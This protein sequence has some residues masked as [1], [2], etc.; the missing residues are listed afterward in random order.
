MSFDRGERPRYDHRRSGSRTFD[1]RG[2][3]SSSASDPV[4]TSLVIVRRGFRLVDELILLGWTII[5]TVIAHPFNYAQVLMQ[6]KNNSE[7]NGGYS[8]H[9]QSFSVHSNRFLWQLLYT[10]YVQKLRNETGEK[11]QIRVSKTIPSIVE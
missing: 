10:V 1:R 7:R 5:P 11:W 6:V 4:R 9:L 2:Q 8:K 3:Y